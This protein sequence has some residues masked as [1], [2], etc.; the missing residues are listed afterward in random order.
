M[1]LVL[2]LPPKTHRQKTQEQA[3]RHLELRP[4]HCCR[5]RQD[6]K[7]VKTLDLWQPLFQQL[8]LFYPAALFAGIVH[9]TGHSHHHHSPT[10]EL[11]G[12]QELSRDGLGLEAVPVGLSRVPRERGACC[13]QSG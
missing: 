10:V 6:A 5:D 4:G 9:A 8:A 13:C 12:M 7:D 2:L 11:A 3:T 1:R